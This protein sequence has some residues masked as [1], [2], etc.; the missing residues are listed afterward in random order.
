MGIRAGNTNLTVTVTDTS[1]NTIGSAAAFV[2]V[3][4]PDGIFKIENGMYNGKFFTA[5]KTLPSQQLSTFLN[6][7]SFSGN[8]PVTDQITQMWR[9]KHVVYNIYSIR[10]YFKLDMRLGK[11]NNYAAV[12]DYIEWDDS[13]NLLYSD[14]ICQTD[15]SSSVTERQE[16]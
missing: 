9:I 7:Y 1:N 5:G 13:Y 3:L 4:I 14:G 16:C 15:L 10:P 12:T 2:F 11:G 6:M 8:D